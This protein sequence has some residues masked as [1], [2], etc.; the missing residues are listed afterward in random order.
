M[1]KGLLVASIVRGQTSIIPNGMTEILP[2]DHVIV[3][4]KSL[5]LHDINEI[6]EH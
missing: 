1:R 5:F 3:M 2:G 4:A 6:L